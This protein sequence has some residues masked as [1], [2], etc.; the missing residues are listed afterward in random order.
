MIFLSLLLDMK[1]KSTNTIS[2]NSKDSVKFAGNFQAT[3][4][5]DVHLMILHKLAALPK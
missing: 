1:S 4:P 5:F 3:F 2:H